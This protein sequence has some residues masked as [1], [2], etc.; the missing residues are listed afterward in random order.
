M[1]KEFFIVLILIFLFS[2]NPEKKSTI[3]SDQGWRLGWRMIENSWDDNNILAEAQFDSLLAMGETIDESFIINGLKIK[4]K[5]SKTAEVLKIISN[6]PPEILRRFCLQNISKEYEI[7]KNQLVEKVENEALQLRILKLFVD[8]QAIRGNIM[9]DII[10]KYKIDTTGIKTEYDWS[11]P[12]EINI[13]EINRNQLKL[14]FEEHG[15]PTKELV[16]K[17]AM[18]GIFLI[19]QHADGD[20]EWQKSQLPNI[21]LAVKNGALSKQNYAYLF[22]RIKVNEDSPQRFGTQFKKVDIE[23][24]IAELRETEDLENLDQRRR[25]M[26]MMPIGMYKRLMLSD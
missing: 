15:F 9:H 17:D 24:K 21:E 8:D 10:S 19:I 12:D 23:H 6:Q 4:S 18:R 2:C 5:R 13:D 14:I 25:E 20:K 1:N 26:G 22:D 11:N 3:M 7:C 16:G